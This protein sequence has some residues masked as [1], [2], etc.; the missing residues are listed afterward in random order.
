MMEWI[1]CDTEEKLKK[2]EIIASP[3]C[4]ETVQKNLELMERKK[5]R[6]IFL[7]YIEDNIPKIAMKFIYK[8]LLDRYKI[9]HVQMANKSYL[10][11]VHKHIKKL[12]IE[13]NKGF[14]MPTVFMTADN[15]QSILT[16]GYKNKTINKIWE[17]LGINM[18]I[19]GD[20]T[21]F[22]LIKNG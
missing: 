5:G 2:W 1:V 12:M 14:Y 20:I 18:I 17:S 22:E 9:S 13:T 15:V 6:V 11:E 3:L 10:L 8:T 21:E 4:R 19:N 16:D 7:V